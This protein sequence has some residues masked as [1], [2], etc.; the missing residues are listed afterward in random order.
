[1]LA[2]FVIALTFWLVSVGDNA[3]QQYDQLA[4]MYQSKSRQQDMLDVAE[5]IER[6]FRDTGSY[7]DSLA[8]LASSSGFQYL[9]SS[10]NAWQGY[11]V[12]G[13]LADTVWTFKRVVAFTVDP[14]RGETAASYLAANTCGTGAYD[15]A[16]YWCGSKTSMWFNRESR[17][18]RNE[19]IVAQRARLKR[20]DQKLAAYGN[21]TGAFPSVT[22]SGTALAASSV[23]ALADLAGYGGT[24]AACSGQY[25][26]RNIPLGCDDMFDVWGAKVGYQFESTHRVILVAEPPFMN[27]LGNRIVIAIDRTL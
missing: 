19:E 6:Y 20:L 9:Q 22:A 16:T 10:L 23:T 15:S 5:G 21:A 1:M 24:G 11:G 8:A 26:Y 4:T 12:S 18:S 3:R 25:Q 2:L 17:E 13:D 7:P 14:S 27:A